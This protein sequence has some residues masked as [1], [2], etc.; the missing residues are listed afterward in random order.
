MA[1]LSKI[2]KGLSWGLPTHCLGL[3][4]V[5]NLLND[6]GHLALEQ[7]VEHLDEEDEA[8]AEEYQGASQQD[9]PHGQVR[10]P[11]VHEDVVACG[12]VEVAVKLSRADLPSGNQSPT[13]ATLLVSEP[14]T[15]PQA[16]S[17][18]TAEPDPGPGAGLV[19]ICPS[20]AGSSSGQAGDGPASARLCPAMLDISHAVGTHI[21]PW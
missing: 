12:W 3:T 21:S 17:T 7:R 14:K 8:G 18:S 2:Q 9:E 1:G 20:G 4:G 15:P 13:L 6:L 16:P 5:D 19:G 10:Q 11:C